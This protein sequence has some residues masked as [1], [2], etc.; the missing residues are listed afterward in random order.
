MPRLRPLRRYRFPATIISHWA[1]ISSLAKTIN[2][3][4]LRSH[5]KPA[6]AAGQIDSVFGIASSARHRNSSRGRA[7]GIL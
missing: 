7:G 4:S 3:E 1:E 5:A 6:D 2:A